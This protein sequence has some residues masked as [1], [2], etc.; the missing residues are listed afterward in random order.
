MAAR[1]AV[2]VGGG[3]SGL[4]TAIALSGRGWDVRVL[5]RAPEFAE[6]GAGISL[7]SNALRA[8]EAIGPGIADKVRGLGGAELYGGIQ[9]R[10][11][12]WLTRAD[13]V[14]LTRRLGPVLMLHRADLLRTL[15][16][17]VAPEALVAGAEVTGVGFDG[18]SVTVTYTGGEVRGDLLVG[19][20]GIR[21]TVRR[22]VWPDVAAPRYAGYTAWRWVTP[23]LPGGPDGGGETWGAGTRF[24]RAPLPDHRMYCYATANTPEGVT[25][26]TGEVAELRARFAK[27]HDPIPALVEAAAGTEVLRHD[28]YELPDVRPYARGRVVLLG[29]AAHAMTPNL[30]QGACQALEDAATLGAVLAR[31]GDVVP[32]LVRYDRLRRERTQDIVKRSRQMGAMGQWSSPVAVAVRDRLL[33]LVPVKIA[34]RTL[35]PVV[36]WQPPDQ[37]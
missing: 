23:P 28:I 27:W 24:G 34:M 26:P 12:R 18:R 11:G 1:T 2:V 32:A 13:A 33:A 37:R 17:A 30:G 3:I 7:W 5:E 25:G 35:A 6:V 22:L 10:N 31:D 29:D 20:D 36:S 16:D 14:E 15:L 19:A 8:L 9:H 21:S 4:A